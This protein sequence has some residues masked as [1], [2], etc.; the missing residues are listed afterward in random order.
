MRGRGIP[1]GG[2]RARRPRPGG[3]VPLLRVVLLLGAAVALAAC[4]PSAEPPTGDAG[5]RPAGDPASAEVPARRAA[6]SFRLPRLGGGE[7]SLSDLRGRVVVIDFWA[8]WCPPCVF[9]IPILNQVHERYAERGVEV[10]GISVDAGGAD[11]VR[12]FAEEQGI[13]YPILLGDESLARAYGAPGYPS[14]VVVAPDGTIPDGP[15]HVGVVDLDELAAEL[16]ALLAASGGEFAAG[17][18]RGSA[19]AE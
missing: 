11:A 19:T 14:L 6:P 15:P 5:S 3:G 7:V 9:Q 13:A 4:G 8:T 1:E 10:L 18:D 12:E 2:V 16:D 17:D